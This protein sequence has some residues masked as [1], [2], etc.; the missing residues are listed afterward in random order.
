MSGNAFVALHA[1]S[2]LLSGGLLF[3]VIVSDWRRR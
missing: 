1:A 3:Y 2:I